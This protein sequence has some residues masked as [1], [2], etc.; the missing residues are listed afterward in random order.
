[1]VLNDETK[2]QD[3]ATLTFRARPIAIEIEQQDG[4]CILR[5]KGRFVAGTEIEYLKTKTEDI[6]RVACIKVLADFQD[7]TAVGSMGIN[8][9]VGIY[10]S[11]TQKSG[12]RFVLT[13]VNPLVQHV[14]DLTRL[15]TVIPLAA[16]LA[17]GLAVLRA[18]APVGPGGIALDAALDG[19]R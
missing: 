13:G 1:M 4:I 14:L 3:R 15:S 12:G 17:T 10:A 11:V 6:K 2:K 9:I 8:F 7:V 19:F 18:G 16:D 5:C